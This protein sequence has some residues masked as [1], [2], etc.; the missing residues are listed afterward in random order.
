MSDMSSIGPRIQA[1]RAKVSQL[2]Q[3]AGTAPG[4][5]APLGFGLA[6]QNAS[7]DAQT[8][9]AA[10]TATA[11][12]TATAPAGTAPMAATG[13][14][15]DPDVALTSPAA[16]PALLLEGRSASG[17][18][19]LTPATVRSGSYGR[20]EPPAEL[21]SFGNGRIPA[22]SLA[23]VGDTGHRLY[24]P[25]ADALNILRADAEAAGVTIGITDSYRPLAVQESLAERKGLYSQ[26]G[27]AA[28]PGTSN[29]GWGLATDL[30]LDG[31][32]LAWM[33]ANASRYGFVEDVP[34]EPWHWTYRP[35]PT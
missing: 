18:V 24:Q 8:A 33:R 11:A 13:A 1:I 27:L 14:A 31:S 21:I 3:V 16:S 9:P 29:H 22:E 34:R 30:N 32:A 23:P 15:S 4:D 35:D 19:A 25:A 5:G 6:L 20:L 12:T 17:A 10:P 2:Q 28:V 26:G 7:L